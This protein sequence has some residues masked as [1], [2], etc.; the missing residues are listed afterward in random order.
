MESNEH[1]SLPLAALQQLP[2]ADPV[3]VHWRLAKALSTMQK[4]QAIPSGSV[5]TLRRL[6]RSDEVSVTMPLLVIILI[7]TSLRPDFLTFK[8]FSAMFTQIPFIAVCSLGA[9]FPLMTGNV[10]ISTGR[11][12]GFAG[13]IMASFVCDYG[14]S[15]E[16]AMLFALACC[17]LIGLLN[18]L[19][20]VHFGVPDFVATMTAIKPVDE[21]TLVATARKT[22]LVVTCENHN[23]FGGVGS[24]VAECLCQ[25]CPVPMRLVGVRD[26]YGWSGELEDLVI[27]FGLTTDEILKA[28]HEL[29]TIKR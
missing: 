4:S 18:G 9:A 15:G 22:G 23:I 24:A 17:V 12:A 3:A 10:D 1:I 27:M 28:A 6:L 8:N 19:L 2:Q 21:E 7:T 5:S 11:V 16:A 13:I 14:W 20:V 26:Q 25:K 29:L